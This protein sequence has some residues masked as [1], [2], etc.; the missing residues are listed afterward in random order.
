M[1]LKPHEAKFTRKV[2]SGVIMLNLIMVT[3]FFILPRADFML[4]HWNEPRYEI[5]KFAGTYDLPNLFFK[6]YQSANEIKVRVPE[7]ATLLMPPRTTAGMF[8]S[9]AQ[10]VLFPR[11]L[12]FQGEKEYGRV[13]DAALVVPQLWK[14]NAPGDSLTDC[15]RASAIPLG[16][17]GF[18]LCRLDP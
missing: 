17:S 15:P 6:T 3:V 4:R 7:N 5:S 2:F 10:Q 12:Y 8:H 14:V 9:A 18:S 16:Q 1:L 13:K 11:T